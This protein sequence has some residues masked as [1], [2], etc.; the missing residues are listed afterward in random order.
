MQDSPSLLH[1]TLE[2][3]LGLKVLAAGRYSASKGQDYPP[4]YHPALEIIVFQSGQIECTIGH[5]PA[6]VTSVDAHLETFEVA[7][8]E[9]GPQS[10]QQM[11]ATRP[12]MV[13]AMPPH[14]IHADRAL[15]A[16]S[17]FYLLLGLPLGTKVP[18]APLVFMDDLDQSLERIMGSL[19]REWHTQQANREVMLD[20][21]LS[22]LQIHCER[23]ET[24]PILSNAEQV[25]RLA[26]RMMADHIAEPQ[27]ISEIALHLGI[28]NSALRAYFANLR[29]H[30]PKQHQQH[31]RMNRALEL[32]RASSLSLDEIA[33]LTGYDSASHLSRQVKA[34]S[35]L[36]PGQFR[37]GS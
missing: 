12:G 18:S 20:L 24:N 31:L 14:T 2:P 19:A 6:P 34:A 15:T 16:Y 13:L 30:S 33:L 32:I 21:L 28:S 37:A 11:I 26:E 25:V 23:L 35:G 1:E 3:A 4:H 10:S 17:H 5:G 22:Q 9:M 27:S 29:G 36:T 7:W 8:N